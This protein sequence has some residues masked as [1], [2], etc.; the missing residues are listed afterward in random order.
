VLR[1]H[2]RFAKVKG[3]WRFKEKAIELRGGF[4]RGANPVPNAV[5]ID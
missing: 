1:H 4:K 3:E 2:D 5:S